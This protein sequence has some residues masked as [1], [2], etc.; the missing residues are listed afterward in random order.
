MS[1]ATSMRRT[2][3]ASLMGSVLEWYDFYLYGTAAALVLGKLYFPNSDPSTATILALLTFA[4]GFLTRPV[5]A[6]IF[7]HFGDRVGRKSMLVITM[8]IM[9]VATLGIGL[10][11]TY[12]TWGIWASV[13]LVTLRLVQG[14]AIGGE[15]GGATLLT[16]ESSPADRRGFYGSVPQ[17]GAPIGLLLSAGVFALASLLPDAQFESWG[18][19]MP[20]LLSGLLLAAGLWVRLGITETEAFAAVT[21]KGH[22]TA[23]P[24]VTLLRHHWKE[25][26]LALGARLADAATFNVINVFAISY[27]ASTLNLGGGVVLTG[28]TVSSA[29]QIVLIPWFGALSDRLG[30]RP[31]YV[32]GAALCGVGIFGYFWALSTASTVVIWVAII[33]MHAVG[34]GLMVSIQSSF[35]AEMFGTNV[36][37]SGISVGYQMAALVGGAPTPAIAAALVAWASGASWPVSIYL[38][39]MC[40]ITIACVFAAGETRRRDLV[41]SSGARTPEAVSQ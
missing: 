41:G 9:G 16:V 2:T 8:M 6:V 18:W 4:S 12:E 40:A 29:V 3:A 39:I 21:E 38:L 19:R 14:V 28:F 13:T 33:V 1:K 24:I 7:G 27:A 17:L 20:F 36:R 34:T 5:G 30:R 15:W 25:T 11:P 23:M 31:V 37:Y 10:V 22:K 32:A 26:L 35:F